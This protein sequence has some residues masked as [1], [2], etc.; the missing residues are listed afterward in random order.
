M[1]ERLLC[2]QQAADWV[3]AQVVGDPQAWVSRVHT[4]SRTVQ[5]GDLFVALKGDQFDG[6]DYLRQLS[7][8]GVTLAM[9]ERGLA[10]AGLSG[11]LVPD[12]R[13]ALGRLAQGWRRQMPLQQ[14]IAVTGSN[15]KTTVTQMIASILRVHA[16]EASLSDRKSTRLNSSHT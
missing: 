3:G 6:H 5:A 8:Q 16:G 13:A 15:G 9:A 2:L 4:D 12:T 1:S 7:G 10:D 11:L 14:L